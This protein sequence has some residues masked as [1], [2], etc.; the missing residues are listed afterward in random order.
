MNAILKD[1]DGIYWYD[2]RTKYDCDPRIY[3]SQSQSVVGNFSFRL[4]SQDRIYEDTAFPI[5][6][7]RSIFSNAEKIGAESRYKGSIQIAILRMILDNAIDTCVSRIEVPVYDSQWHT[8]DININL[9][10]GSKDIWMYP[11][12]STKSIGFKPEEGEIF[13]KLFRSNDY[14]R[15]VYA[16][17]PYDSK[18][19]KVKG[20]EKLSQ[21]EIHHNPSMKDIMEHNFLDLPNIKKIYDLKI[22]ISDLNVKYYDSNQDLWKT[23]FPDLEDLLRETLVV[24]AQYNLRL[25]PKH[26]HTHC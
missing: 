7:I 10:L 16:F 15:Q 4:F 18:W 2:L 24:L 20:I 17:N 22:N 3:S 26:L 8:K 25:V 14:V 6:L 21:L 9:S 1:S 5:K 12:E 23:L 13:I 11:I 19:E